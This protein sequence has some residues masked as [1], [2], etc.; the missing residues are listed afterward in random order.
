MTLN[1]SALQRQLSLSGVTVPTDDFTG[2]LGSAQR[3][4]DRCANEASAYDRYAMDGHREDMGDSREKC[5]KREK[6]EK[7]V[8]NRG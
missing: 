6:R 2:E 3:H 1:R 5:E 8:P 4:A 7:R